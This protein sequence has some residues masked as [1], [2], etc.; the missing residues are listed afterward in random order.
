MS[1]FAGGGRSCKRSSLI[2]KC[3]SMV[4]MLL[5]I[6][7]VLQIWVCCHCQ[8]GAIRVFP[9]HHNNNFTTTTTSTTTYQKQKQKKKM[10]GEALLQKYLSG[11][12][13]HVSNT[14]TKG[15]ENS[16]RRV[17]SCPDPLHN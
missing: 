13:F 7:F 6:V 5:M 15:F 3:S 11:R 12:A 10:K 1:S 16:K 9:T 17:P 8:A 4:V 2:F 14:T